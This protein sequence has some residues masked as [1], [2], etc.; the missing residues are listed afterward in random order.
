MRVLTWS[1]VLVWSYQR[2][3]TCCWQRSCIFPAEKG[4]DRL[5]AWLTEY[6]AWFASVKRVEYSAL[7]EA[8]FQR[9]QP[10]FIN[11]NPFLNTIFRALQYSF[12]II[13]NVW[14]LKKNFCRLFV[15][16]S[17]SSV[18]F[19]DWKKIFCNFLL[20]KFHGT[21]PDF[22]KFKRLSY[23]VS[24]FRKREKPAR[25]CDIEKSGVHGSKPASVE[26]S[27]GSAFPCFPDVRLLGKRATDISQLRSSNE[28]KS[29][30]S[31]FERSAEF[32]GNLS[33][34][35]AP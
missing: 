6:S 2:A 24:K 26:K 7:F 27:R 17:G 30:N 14:D 11:E 15:K 35:R 21:L 31:P 3:Q 28:Q 34:P 25:K 33:S 8:R 10:Q 1:F 18:K 12:Y 29:T 32:G 9:Y 19:H 13:P 23:L 20:F 4:T 16:V 5:P 22:A